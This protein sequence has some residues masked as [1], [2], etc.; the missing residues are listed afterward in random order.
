MLSRLTASVVGLLAFAGCIVVGLAAGNPASTILLRA[1]GGLAGGMVVGYATGCVAQVVVNEQFRAMVAADIDAE[2]TAR[3]QAEG[4]Q[5]DQV[6]V[7]AAD[8]SPSSTADLAYT[9]D[10]REEPQ[11]PVE[12]VTLAA[13]AAKE[14]LPEAQ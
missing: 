7:D 3:S 14:L 8:A 10:G 11:S 6:S 12:Q 5:D 9:E 1:L 13:R 2:T 4:S